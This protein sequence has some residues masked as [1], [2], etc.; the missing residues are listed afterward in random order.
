M[1]IG[2][3]HGWIFPSGFFLDLFQMEAYFEKVFLAPWRILEGRQ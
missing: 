1:D 2:F 3:S